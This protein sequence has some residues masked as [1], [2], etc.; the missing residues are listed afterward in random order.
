MLGSCSSSGTG[1]HDIL[2]CGWTTL[3]GG[4][5]S[6]G[7]S[8][9]PP[10]QGPE[11]RPSL[12]KRGSLAWRR[13]WPS[14]QCRSCIP[15]A[16]FSRMPTERRKVLRA[17][18]VSRVSCGYRSPIRASSYG[19]QRFLSLHRGHCHRRCPATRFLVVGRKDRHVAD[20][21]LWP[22]AERF[23]QIRTLQTGNKLARRNRTVN[24]GMFL[25]VCNGYSETMLNEKS[26]AAYRVA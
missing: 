2:A 25:L 12:P 3:T 11:A 14:V 18:Q 6:R 4:A 16:W 10:G 17:T 1:L 13:P 21:P 20:A 23:G 26:M 19:R 24:S 8:G 7:P 9:A 5:G 22:T 15:F